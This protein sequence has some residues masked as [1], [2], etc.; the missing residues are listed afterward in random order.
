MCLDHI[1]ISR[2]WA[3]RCI[4]V[5]ACSF[6][7]VCPPVMEPPRSTHA[8]TDPRGAA[9]LHVAAMTKSVPIVALLLNARAYVNVTMARTRVC[10]CVLVRLCAWPYAM[11]TATSRTSAHDLPCLPPVR[12]SQKAH[13]STP[14]HCAAA[15]G[16]IE[17]TRL[18]LD[19]GAD[20]SAMT[21]VGSPHHRWRCSLHHVC[22][23]WMGTWV[24]LP[25]RHR[26]IALIRA[27][28]CP[29]SRE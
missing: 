12:R 6:G 26:V 5:W 25:A 23:T 19:A 11:C 29:A 16:S 8:Q 28:Q 20:A 7:F 18:L 13:A 9:A 17:I 15:G 24:L 2:G 10:G 22:A 4:A 1:R 3:S 14:L 21:T 27:Y